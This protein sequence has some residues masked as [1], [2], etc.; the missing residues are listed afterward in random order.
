MGKTT[1]IEDTDVIPATSETSSDDNIINCNISTCIKDKILSA[2]DHIKNVRHK[3]ADTDSIFEFTSE[4]SPDVDKC[5]VISALFDLLA[6]NTIT[7]KKYSNGLD[8]HKQIKET[9]DSA[10]AE[11][12]QQLVVSTELSRSNLPSELLTPPQSHID[13]PQVPNSRPVFE[14][15]HKECIV[16]IDHELNSLN[17]FINHEL[18]VLRD[19]MDSLSEGL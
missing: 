1:T 13:T 7:N 18:S 3:R 4:N 6:V 8:F 15:S 14:N 12:E 19:K 11:N 5:I 17:T 2:I 16:Q 10:A 9:V